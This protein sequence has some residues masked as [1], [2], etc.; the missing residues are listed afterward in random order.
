MRQRFEIN[1]CRLEMVDLLI[2]DGRQRDQVA[3]RL[4]SGSPQEEVDRLGPSGN[5]KPQVSVLNRQ[6]LHI[7][8][9]KTQARRRYRG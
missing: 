5:L 8:R 3:A 2:D 7:L 6:P 9:S 1:F 4:H